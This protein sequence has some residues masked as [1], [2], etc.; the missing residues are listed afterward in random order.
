MEEL[1]KKKIMAAGKIA[2]GVARMLSGV[3]TAT[4][5]GVV[6]TYLKN[7]H[8]QRQA[9][10]LGKMGFEAGQKTLERGIEDWKRLG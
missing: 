9:L 10:Q 4:G 3:A 6:G 8:M 5:H 2:F 1:T 7:H